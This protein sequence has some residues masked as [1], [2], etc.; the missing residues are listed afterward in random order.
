MEASKYLLQSFPLITIFLNIEVIKFFKFLSCKNKWKQT[1]IKTPMNWAFLLGGQRLSICRD[2]CRGWSLLSASQDGPGAS[3]TLLQG[4]PGF[5]WH[6]AA[7]EARSS[8][9]TAQ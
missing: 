9:V 4:V 5:H 2:G 1:K 8:T 7:R 3:P 6:L